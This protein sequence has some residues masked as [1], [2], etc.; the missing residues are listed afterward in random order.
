[1]NRTCI[2]LLL[3]TGAGA[4]LACGTC[5]EDK[6]A[7]TYDYAT[8]QRAA[9][10]GR[11][12]VYCELAGPWDAARLKRL[13]ARVRGVEAATVRYA[14]DPAA[15]SFALDTRQASAQQAVLAL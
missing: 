2:A 6:I 14:A 7:A 15:V 11:A 9:A 4:A 13:A 1:M 10:S 5:A 8:A 3:A 12:M